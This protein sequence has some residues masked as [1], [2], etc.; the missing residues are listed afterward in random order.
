MRNTGLS[1][2]LGCFE[3]NFHVLNPPIHS[4]PWK[5]V[6]FIFIAVTQK[7]NSSLIIQQKPH[8]HF[9]IAPKDLS[10]RYWRTI[11]I[12]ML[13]PLFPPISYPL[14]FTSPP[15]SSPD[16]S[17]NPPSTPQNLFPIFPW[18]CTDS[19]FKTT[20]RHRTLLLPRKCRGTRMM[21]DR[22]TPTRLPSSTVC[23]NSS[24]VLPICPKMIHGLASICVMFH[25]IPTVLRGSKIPPGFI[26]FL[27]SDFR[28]YKTHS[29]R[30]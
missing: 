8:S 13:F 9:F 19:F 30:V 25:L 6:D 15:H 12:D 22:T 14:R 26:E 27:A 4:H 20:W 10:H 24:A 2:H 5:S 16:S 18:I 21:L 28:N 11:V 3:H 17:S 1:D 7:T 29:E 23:G